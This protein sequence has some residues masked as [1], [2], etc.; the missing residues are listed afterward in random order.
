[1]DVVPIRFVAVGQVTVGTDAVALIGT[2]GG[3]TTTDT[4]VLDELVQYNGVP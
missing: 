3:F 4:G 2:G 1:M